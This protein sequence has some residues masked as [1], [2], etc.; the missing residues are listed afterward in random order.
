MRTFIMHV[1][2]SK[3]ERYLYDAF[4]Y[5]CKYASLREPSR[6]LFSPAAVPRFHF[7][8]TPRWGGQRRSGMY[9]FQDKKGILFETY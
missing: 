7:L 3:R 6:I 4:V 9:M 2:A 5:T 8:V 1:L